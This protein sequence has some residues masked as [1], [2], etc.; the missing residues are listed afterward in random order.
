MSSTYT[1]IGD[2]RNKIALQSRVDVSDGMGGFTT[3]WT[4]TA[5][6][7]AKVEAVSA[8]ENFFAGKIKHRVTHKVT[9]RKRAGVEASM[10][11]LFRGITL[12]VRGIGPTEYR[13]RFLVLD[14]EQGVAS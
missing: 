3:Q 14:C 13:D 8:R 12:Q 7:Q 5:N 11:I 9:I 4:T 6:I 2:L 10:R 1:R